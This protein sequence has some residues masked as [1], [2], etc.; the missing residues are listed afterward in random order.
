M[1]C[2]MAQFSCGAPGALGLNAETFDP[3]VRRAG[4]FASIDQPRER[5]IWYALQCVPTASRRPV[6]KYLF[7]DG[8]SGFKAVQ[9]EPGDKDGPFRPWALTPDGR[10]VY[11]EWKQTGSGVQSIFD[12]AFS[13]FKQRTA[14]RTY[15]KAA[16]QTRRREF[17]TELARDAGAHV[18]CVKPA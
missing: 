6:M 17:E 18:E 1:F 5:G 8:D 12:I 2:T 14:L 7:R 4:S 9:G 11:A 13:G 3:Q 10:V 16:S 15:D